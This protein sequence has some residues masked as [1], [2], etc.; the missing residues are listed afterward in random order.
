ME[1]VKARECDTSG[2]TKRQH[3]VREDEKEDR[4]RTGRCR[5]RTVAR[6]KTTDT[7]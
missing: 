4:V 1:R 7:I 3:V 6:G 2:K 5:K